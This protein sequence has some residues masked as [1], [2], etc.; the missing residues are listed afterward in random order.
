MNK[1]IIIISIHFYNKSTVFNELSFLI[2]YI[3]NSSIL[4]SFNMML[5]LIKFTSIFMASIMHKVS[6]F[7]T[8]YPYL[9]NSLK[10]V[11]GIGDNT[12]LD[13]T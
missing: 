5:Y 7:L 8:C 2:I 13:V 11:P 4:R 10:I 12:Y 6:F 9:T 3:F 1:I